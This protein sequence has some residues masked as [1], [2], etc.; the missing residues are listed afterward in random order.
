[1]ECSDFS[2]PTNAC[3][4]YCR[5]SHPFFGLLKQSIYSTTFLKEIFDRIQWSIF[6]KWIKYM[7]ET[8]GAWMMTISKMGFT[9]TILSTI[10]VAVVLKH[11]DYLFI[12]CVSPYLVF[13]NCLALYHPPL[14][15]IFVKQIL[16]YLFCYAFLFVKRVIQNRNFVRLFFFRLVE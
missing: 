12:G 3:Y 9:A 16:V 8:S 7:D 2:D 4:W 11:A 1:M 15:I 5:F 14:L 6:H 13:S 10:V